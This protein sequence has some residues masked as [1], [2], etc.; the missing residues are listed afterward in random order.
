MSQKWAD[1]HVQR[2]QSDRSP[3][4][5]ADECLW[6]G[7][8]HMVMSFWRHALA[9]WPASERGAPVERCWFDV[10]SAKG[11]YSRTHA[12]RRCL[13]WRSF[14]SGRF[15]PKEERLTLA[16]GGFSVDSS[17]WC[18][19]RKKKA[20]ERDSMCLVVVFVTVGEK[21]TVTRTTETLI[22]HILFKT[23][24]DWQIR[25]IHRTLCYSF[26]IWHH[27]TCSSCVPKYYIGV[28]AG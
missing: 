19:A 12:A 2:G 22:C 13:V 4:D 5:T 8:E 17:E 1:R 18:Q 6:S 27:T 14:Q 20:Q 21:F 24:K 23:V 3:R 28:S 11:W 16:G 26:T 15:W 10:V 9:C 7:E 25:V